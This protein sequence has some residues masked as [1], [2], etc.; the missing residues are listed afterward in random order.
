MSDVV[1]KAGKQCDFQRRALDI[2]LEANAVATVE[3]QVTQVRGEAPSSYA[4]GD[5]CGM[6]NWGNGLACWTYHRIETAPGSTGPN[7]CTKTALRAQPGAS[8]GQWLHS[9]NVGPN[10]GAVWWVTADNPA[11][12]GDASYA[13]QWV[14]G[15][16]GDVDVAQAVI[17]WNVSQKST[18]DFVR[19]TRQDGKPGWALRIGRDGSIWIND[20]SLE[21][22][23]DE[24]I[25]K[26][27]SR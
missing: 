18:G 24:R 21:Q 23:V 6:T 27:Q 1:V 25:A 7:I 8:Y 17:Q 2:V 15:V 4:Y 12:Y 20:K 5:L 16:M 10:V 11:V 13:T 14:L 26:L 22:I 3:A 9:E 19:L